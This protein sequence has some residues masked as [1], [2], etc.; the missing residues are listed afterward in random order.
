MEMVVGPEMMCLGPIDGCRWCA[1]AL[2]GWRCGQLAV[3]YC[4]HVG[5]AEPCGGFLDGFVGEEMIGLRC[6]GRWF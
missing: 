2:V 4:I 5:D 3:G 1:G 6:G